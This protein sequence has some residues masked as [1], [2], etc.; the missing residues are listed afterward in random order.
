MKQSLVVVCLLIVQ[1]VSAQNDWR[2]YGSEKDDSSVEVVEEEIVLVDTNQM[3]SVIILADPKIDS[4]VSLMNEKPPS[5]K[6]YR[7]EIFFGQR[8]DAEKVKSE[9]L[10]QYQEWPIYVVW[11]QPNFKVQIGDFMTKLQADKT[12]QEIKSKYPNSYITITDIKVND[13]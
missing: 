7:V 9:F 11:Q 5:L 2:L 3:G 12:Q 8:K 13:E 1:I 6:G 10:K 4:L